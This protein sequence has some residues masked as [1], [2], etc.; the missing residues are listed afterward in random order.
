MLYAARGHTAPE[1]I[2]ARLDAG[3]TDLGLT[4]CKGNYPRK[5]GLKISEKLSERKGA[6]QAEPD[7]FRLPGYRRMPG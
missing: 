6:E 7:C 5:F 3:K 2:F 1:L 4:T